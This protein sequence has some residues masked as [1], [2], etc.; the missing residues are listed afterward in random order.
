MKRI[1]L[2]IGSIV[3]AVTVAVVFIRYKQTKIIDET[4]VASVVKKRCRYQV[5]SPPNLLSEVFLG[6]LFL[7]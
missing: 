7:P 2:I 4:Y 5:L 3:V 6:L 1:T